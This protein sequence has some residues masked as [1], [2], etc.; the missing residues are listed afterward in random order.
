MVKTAICENSNGIDMKVSHQRWTEYVCVYLSFVWFFFLHFIIL[1]YEYLPYHH[2][3]SRCGRCC[4]F[5]F[6]QFY[7]SAVVVGSSVFFCFL[8][9]CKNDYSLLSFIICLKHAILSLNIVDPMHGRFASQLRLCTECD[10]EGDMLL[11]SL[12]R[13][14]RDNFDL[15]WWDAKCK[16]RIN[17]FGYMLIRSAVL[18]NFCL[19]FFLSFCV[20]VAL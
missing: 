3:V 20:F 1:I 4:W 6:G 19:S 11:C 17:T 15:E 8:F 18:H 12:K 2:M 14:S 7:I 10:R 5:C 13:R 16:I 9:S